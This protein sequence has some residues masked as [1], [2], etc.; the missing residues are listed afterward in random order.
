MRGGEAHKKYC[1]LRI[2]RAHADS[3]LD[4]NAVQKNSV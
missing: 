2:V 1:V 4:S 3:L